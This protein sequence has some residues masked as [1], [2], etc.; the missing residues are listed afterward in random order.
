MS[1]LMSALVPLIIPSGGDQQA[2]PM[3]VPCLTQ[4]PTGFALIG[5]FW[6]IRRREATPGKRA[7]LG[8][9]RCGS[10][11]QLCHTELQHHAR[12]L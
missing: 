2:L 1:V 9:R 5:S 6:K 7:E 4:D 3:A 12:Q 8:D 11:H 10:E